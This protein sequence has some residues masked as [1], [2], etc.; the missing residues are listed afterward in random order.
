VVFKRRDNRPWLQVVVSWVYPRGGWARAFYYVRHR[1][2]RLPGSP[3]TIARGIFAGAFTVFTPFYGMHFIVAA[4]IAKTMRGNILAALLATFL[5]NPLTYI[6]IAI[7]SLKAGHFMLG[8]EPRRAV[9][10]NLGQKFGGAFQDLFDNF[11][12]IF[13]HRE[14]HWADLIAFYHDVFFPYLVGGIIPGLISGTICYI[15]AV[16]VI[17]AYQ[18]RRLSKLLARS[19]KQRKQQA[20]AAAAKQ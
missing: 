2:N 11:L 6:P 9:D 1:L 3:E 18:K 10:L 13:T 20:D 8:I 16:P 4:I 14:P 7:I 5:G 12:A 17:R 19:K 15:L